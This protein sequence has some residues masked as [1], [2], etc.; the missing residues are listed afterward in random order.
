PPDFPIAD[1]RVNIRQC[2]ACGLC[3]R[4]CPPGALTFLS[5]GQQFALG[6]YSALCL[7]KECHICELACPE[8]A[9]TLTPPP[10]SPH[11]LRKKPRY[12]AAGDLTTC[13]KC[14]EPIAAGPDFPSTCYACRPRRDLSD[15]LASFVR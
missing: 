9:I 2:T 7:G 14:G 5:D 15:F 13:E 8:Q 1:V 11:L 3:A 12:L 6:F 10:L 4:F